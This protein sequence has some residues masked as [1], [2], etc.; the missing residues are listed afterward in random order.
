[1]RDFQRMEKF[2]I[3]LYGCGK[4]SQKLLQTSL[5]N[6]TACVTC[7]HDIDRSRAELL[8][9]QYGARAC[10]L[11]ELLTAK[12][13]DMYL[14]SLFPAAHPDAL[15]AAVQTNK[16]VYIEKPVAVFMPEICR[17]RE[18]CGKHYIN[19]GLFYQYMPIYRQLTHLVKSGMLGDL[20]AMNFNWLQYRPELRKSVDEKNPDWRYVPQTGGELTQHYCHCFEWFRLLNGPIEQ[21]YAM[22]N[23]HSSNATCV[24][25]IWDLLLK[26]R[27]GCQISFH[28]SECNP[29]CTVYG[30]IEGSEGALS[31]EYNDPSTIIYHKN[32]PPHT[33]GVPVEINIPTPD[34][35]EDFIDRWRKGLPPAVSL[36]EGLWAVI[37]PLYARKSAREGRLVELPQTLAELSPNEDI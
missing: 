20:V 21:L 32:A 3:G 18:L 12:D 22:S 19:V 29:R 2:R 28:S 6:G 11:D 23:Q 27:N 4:R 10:S 34:A 13:V 25:D 16:P 5:A 1:M 9:K 14:I 17:V 30:S 35:I 26:H 31:W 37:P 15:F 8:A 36:E 33:P 7:C 24:E